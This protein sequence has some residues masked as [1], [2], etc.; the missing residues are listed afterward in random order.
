M[1]LCDAIPDHSFLGKRHT[2]LSK[3][4]LL[5]AQHKNLKKKIFQGN[6]SLL[7][8]CITKMITLDVYGKYK[9]IWG[10]YGLHKKAEMEEYLISL[11]RR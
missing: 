4:Y 9:N 11:Q 5:T 7:R 10:I 6:T 3:L 8:H 1:Y 2:D